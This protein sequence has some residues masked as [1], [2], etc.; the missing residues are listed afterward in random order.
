MFSAKRLSKKYALPPKNGPVPRQPVNG[1]A[2][3]TGTPWKRLED[4]PGELAVQESIVVK[5][6]RPQGAAA[7][8]APQKLPS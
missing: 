5:A 6:P 4:M 2:A 1:Y 8:A 7:M 3:P